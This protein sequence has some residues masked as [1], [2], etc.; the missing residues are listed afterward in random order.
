MAIDAH[1]HLSESGLWGPRELAADPA[2]LLRQMDE[3]EIDSA[4]LLP[5]FG[6]DNEDWAAETASASQGRIKAFVPVSPL[7]ES[8]AARL[9]RIRRHDA[10]GM[11]LHPRFQGLS[12]GDQRVISFFQELQ[13]EFSGALL[14]DCFLTDQDPQSRIEE[15]AEFVEQV[16]GLKLILAHSGAFRFERIVPLASR[17]PHVWVD[18]SFT[19]NVFLKHSKHSHMNR[20]ASM[21]RETGPDKVIFGSDFPECPIADSR[22]LM[23]RCLREAGFSASDLNQ[24][25][26]A[27]ILSIL[28]ERDA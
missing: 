9:Q 3:A 7:T 13:E 16:D 5:I 2:T 4:V 26:D 10:K 19:F 1:V 23:Q 24:V 20:L 14:I 15:V 12:L 21:L 8:P 25:L 6:R 27:N 17:H 11:K 22:Q 18:T 28:G